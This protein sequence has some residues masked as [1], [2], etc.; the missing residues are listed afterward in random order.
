[1]AAHVRTYVCM[2]VCTYIYTYLRKPPMH[3][4]SLTDRRASKQNPNCWYTQ[5]Q[6]VLI[7][8]SLSSCEGVEKPLGIKCPAFEY[9]KNLCFLLVNLLSAYFS[10]PP[11]P[12]TYPPTKPNHPSTVHPP[13]HHAHLRTYPLPI[14]QFLPSPTTP[15][16]PPIHHAHSRTYP[17]PTPTYP[18]TTPTRTSISRPSLLAVLEGSLSQTPP[19]H[20]Q[21][22]GCLLHQRC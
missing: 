7:Q 3:S 19:G 12:T 10:L 17:L 13:I 9:Y 15:I 5:Q 1:M 16:Y 18:P 21:C 11:P 14:L 20:P 2:Q 8:R 6:D 4:H 22:G